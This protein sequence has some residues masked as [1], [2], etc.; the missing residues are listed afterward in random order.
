MPGRQN[1]RQSLQPLPALSSPRVAGLLPLAPGRP[2][3]AERIVLVA[4][5]ALAAGCAC[6]DA[7]DNNVDGE[8]K[9]LVA[10]TGDHLRGVG[11]EKR[12]AGRR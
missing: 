12:E 3:E 10:V 6:H 1:G 5:H 7:V 8:A 11:G 9:P 4:T 2:L